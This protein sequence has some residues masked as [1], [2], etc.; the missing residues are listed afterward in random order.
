MGIF[1]GYDRKGV[2]YGKHKIEKCYDNQG[3][4]YYGASLEDVFPVNVVIVGGGDTPEEA[5]AEMKENARVYLDYI[6]EEA[7][8]EQICSGRKPL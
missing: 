8:N 6:L 2:N 1:H 5:I 3:K 4:T 7:E